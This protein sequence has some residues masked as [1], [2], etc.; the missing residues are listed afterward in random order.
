[1]QVWC[2]TREARE[3]VCVCTAA[4]DGFNQAKDKT[5]DMGGHGAGHMSMQPPLSGWVRC[6]SRNRIHASRHKPPRAA[7]GAGLE[8]VADA[9]GAG[10]RGG[11]APGPPA[12]GGSAIVSSEV[13]NQLVADLVD[14]LCSVEDDEEEGEEGGESGDYEDGL[15]AVDT[16]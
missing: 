16:E 8:V 5:S 4:K 1:M 9:A 3:S 6:C 14:V 15:D 13:A 12:D 10:A 7:G 2:S 11:E